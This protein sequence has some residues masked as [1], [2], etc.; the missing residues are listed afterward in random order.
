[1]VALA[2]LLSSLELVSVTRQLPSLKRQFPSSHAISPVLRHESPLIALD[3]SISS[4][5]DSPPVVMGSILSKCKN[6]KSCTVPAWSIGNLETI[7]PAFGGE[8]D[9]NPEVKS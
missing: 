3:K 8:L 1:M 4:G 7:D 6:L 5:F 2:S 9:F